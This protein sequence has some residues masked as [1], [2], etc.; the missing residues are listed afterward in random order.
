MKVLVLAKTYD[1]TNGWGRY[2]AGFSAEM[3]KR[4]GPEAVVMP[5]PETLTSRTISRRQPFQA[6]RDALKLMKQASGCDGIHAMAEPLAPLAMFLSMLTGKPYVVSVMGTYADLEAYPAG[7]RWF[8]RLVFRRAHGLAVLSH[9][10][11]TVL[12]RAIPEDRMMLVPG[13]FAPPPRPALRE[14]PSPERRILSVGALKPR[15]GFHTLIAAMK[16]LRGGRF[17]VRL[18]IVGPT[19]EKEGYV[20]QLREAI[21]AG[22]L[23]EAVKIRGKIPQAELD[24][25]YA[26]AD[27][28]ALAS[29]HSGPAFEGL[30]LVYLEALAGG[31]PVIGC[32]ESGAEDVIED[33]VNGLLVPPGDPEALAAAIKDILGDAEVW[34]SMSKDGPT[35]VE[36]F[37][38]DVVG[39]TLFS[40]YTKTFR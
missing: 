1:E 40:L 33:G 21:A 27:L 31:V 23:Q 37:R 26:A 39:Q 2:A 30:G 12:K 36:P 19:D 24:G 9:Y 15:K 34:R 38:W 8:Y 14:A 10:T 35:S 18:D 32:R 22:G 6:L 13:G 20:R 4:L 28:F 16:I 5:D 25:L 29:E 17:A 3:K 11:W 7:L